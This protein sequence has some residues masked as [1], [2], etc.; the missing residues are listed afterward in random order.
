MDGIK[1]KK[2]NEKGITLMTLVIT[3]IVLLIIAGVSLNFSKDSI[4]EARENT[5]L[6]ELNMV[7]HAI[8]EKYTKAKVMKDESILP[9]AGVFNDVASSLSSS[10]KY[11]SITDLVSY[12]N[13]KNTDEDITLK[14]TEYSNYV[15]LQQNELKQLGI[16]KT[17]DEYVVNYQTGEVFNITQE[18][19]KSGKALYI[20]AKESE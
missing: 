18:V 2:I 11:T 10:S 14:D 3:I 12:I 17:E 6:T 5:A 8:L 4:K 13:S 9:S 1:M 7:Q 20:Y 16:T 15:L 19:T